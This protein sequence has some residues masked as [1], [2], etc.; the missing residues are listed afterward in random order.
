MSETLDVTIIGGQL[1]EILSTHP[2]PSEA[3]LKVT[4]DTFGPATRT[5][6]R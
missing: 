5:I 4:E 2:L 1:A 3:V 6:R